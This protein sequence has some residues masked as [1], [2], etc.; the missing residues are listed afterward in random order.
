[1]NL[2]F[3]QLQHITR[4][5]FLKSS[6]QLS[7]G[8]IALQ[9]LSGR[10]QGSEINPLA[11]RQS[12]YRPK[13]KRIIYLHMSGAP[14]HLDLFD[15]K[16]E[17]VKRNGQ[18]CPDDFIKGKKFAFTSGTP[19]L[20]GTP[21]KF[22]QYGKGGIWMSDAVPN[23]HTVADEMCVIRSMNTDQFNHAPAELLLFT[24]SPRQGRPLPWSGRPNCFRPKG[25]PGVG[26]RLALLASAALSPLNACSPSS[27]AA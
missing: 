11:P 21:R 2:K 5:Q 1:M 22:A 24:G 16:P 13:A 23:F 7:L 25:N 3:E 14:P 18:L 19:R 6:G 27:S 10:A 15:Y 8:A 20:L 17:L 4:R 9:A 12:H 26:T